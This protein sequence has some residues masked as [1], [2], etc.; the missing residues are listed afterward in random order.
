MI[1]G[2]T[3]PGSFA[4]DV[5][6]A[7]AAAEAAAAICGSMLLPACGAGPGS[8][9]FWLGLYATDVT[10]CLYLSFF[11]ISARSLSAIGL[12]YLETETRT[13]GAQT[14]G[15][16]RRRRRQGSSW[17]WGGKRAGGAAARA[18]SASRNACLMHAP[19]C[20]LVEADSVVCVPCAALT[21]R[22]TAGGR[23]APA[24]LK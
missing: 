3:S 9:W 13:K 19:S 21:V 16:R 17:Y 24:S 15:R 14:G 8:L 5:A 11:S 18:T 12:P 23:C 1:A 4:A 6:T 10:R 22:A 2:M 7:D 20:V